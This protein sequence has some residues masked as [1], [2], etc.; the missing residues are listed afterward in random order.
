MVAVPLLPEVTM[1]LKST[2][3]TDESDEMK[4]NPVVSVCW[5]PSEYWPTIDSGCICPAPMSVSEVGDGAIAT[6]DF[7]RTDTWASGAPGTDTV[8]IAVPLAPDVIRPF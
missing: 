5:E 1:P 6:N 7:T 8:I 2:R 4:L 3:A